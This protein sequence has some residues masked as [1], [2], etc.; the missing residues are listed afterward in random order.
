[1]LVVDGDF[2]APFDCA[3]VVIGA[4]FLKVW[5][6]CRVVDPCIKVEYRRLIFVDQFASLNKPV[7]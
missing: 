3:V 7:G 2:L 5:L 1:M 4:E 6:E